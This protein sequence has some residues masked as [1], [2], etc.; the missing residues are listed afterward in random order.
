MHRTSTIIDRAAPATA[1]TNSTGPPTPLKSVSTSVAD[2][3][4]MSVNSNAA[5]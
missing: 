3:L 1:T 4:K 2:D 5:T